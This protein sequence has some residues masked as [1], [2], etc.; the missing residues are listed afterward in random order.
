MVVVAIVAILAG[1]ALAVVQPTTSSAGRWPKSP[2]CWAT[3]GS[4]WSS[5]FSTSSDLRRRPV[6]GVDQVVHGHVPARANGHGVHDHRH[7]QLRH[8]R[9]HL[10]AE[11][12][13][14]KTS[15]GPWVT[16]TQN[17]WISRRATHADA[18]VRGHIADRDHDRALD[19]RHRAGAGHPRHGRVHRERAHPHRGRRL[20][21][22]HRAGPGRSGAAQ[23]Q[24]GIPDLDRP[25]AGA[26]RD[27]QRRAVSRPPASKPRPTSPPPSRRPTPPGSPSTRSAGSSPR[28]RS[29]A[30]AQSGKSI[31]TCRMAQVSAPPGARCACSFRRAA[32][33]RCAIPL[34]SSTDP[35]ACV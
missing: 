5:T 10:H 25:L 22:R 2:A 21:E 20:F 29:T 3:A 31:S 28:A 30:P 14:A 11:P 23:H 17:C 33:S 34:S 18:Q 26:T 4:S 13:N 27:R 12:A 1:V 8:G 32:R 24:R 9:L 35:R 6:P 19:H 7:G 16:G 15:Q